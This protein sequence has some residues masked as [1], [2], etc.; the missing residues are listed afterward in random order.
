MHFFDSLDLFASFL[1]QGKNEEPSRLEAK[2]TRKKPLR[3]KA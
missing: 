3:I 2:A 1:H